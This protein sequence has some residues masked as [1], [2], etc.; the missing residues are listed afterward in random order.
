MDQQSRRPARASAVS[1]PRAMTSDI[2]GAPRSVGRSGDRSALPD[3]TFAVGRR[4]RHAESDSWGRRARVDVDADLRS[5][6][7]AAASRGEPCASPSTRSSREVRETASFRRRSG[8][9]RRPVSLPVTTMRPGGPRTL[10]R[11]GH[12]QGCDCRGDAVSPCP[13]SRRRGDRRLQGRTGTP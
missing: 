8:A 6:A 3:C 4:M 7:E 11:S 12:H 13:R 5:G 1:T 10:R 9:G 2:R